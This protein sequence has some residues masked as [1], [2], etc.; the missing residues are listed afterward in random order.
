MGTLARQRSGLGDSCQCG[1]MMTQLNSFFFVSNISF[2]LTT[3]SNIT[4]IDKRDYSLN[5][6][7][8]NPLVVFN[9]SDRG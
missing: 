2:C 9:T 7:H 5:E 4:I 1:K 6:L 3:V 8:L